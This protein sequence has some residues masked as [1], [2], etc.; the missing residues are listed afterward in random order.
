MNEILYIT[1]NESNDFLMEYEPK[2]L[3]INIKEKIREEKGIPI[4][5]Q[6]LF[7]NGTELVQNKKLSDY[8]DTRVF[9][10]PIMISI[11]N[12]NHLK[13]KIRLKYISLRYFLKAS[14][15]IL[16]LKKKIF[17][18]EKIPIKNMQI[19]RSGKIVNDN[20]LIEEII[21]D[22]N[23]GEISDL[24]FELKILEKKEIKINIVDGKNI[25]SIY[26]DL[27]DNFTQIENQIHRSFDYR[28]RFKDRFI[29][30]W[31]LLFQYNIRN[32]DNIELIK[33]EG[34]IKLFIIDSK[35]QVVMTVRVHLG[36]KISQLKEYISN[37]LDED[38]IELLYNGIIFNDDETFAGSGVPDNSHLLY[39]VQFR[40]GCPNFN[41]DY[42]KN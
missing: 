4:Y 39:L 16:E 26:V 11:I 41:F 12:L 29:D 32:G 38:E 10:E 18:K 22:L 35:Y 9:S 19:L 24:K 31:K 7:W 25:D 23:Y 33:S 40:A 21:S 37:F 17:E 30:D 15:S 5:C 14:D 20:I 34:K 3:I 2:M 36:Q 27:F 1:S 42:L 13:V 8:K 28:L 6:K